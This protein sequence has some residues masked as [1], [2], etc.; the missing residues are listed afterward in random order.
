MARRVCVAFEKILRTTPRNEPMPDAP[1]LFLRTLNQPAQRGDRLPAVRFD[2]IRIAERPGTRAETGIVQRRPLG[3]LR[4][5]R[6]NGRYL[7]QPVIRAWIPTTAV[8]DRPEEIVCRERAQVR[9]PR[10]ALFDVEW[11][12]RVSRISAPISTPQTSSEP[13]HF[14]PLPG[15]PYRSPSAAWKRATN[16]RLDGMLQPPSHHP[17]LPP[18]SAPYSALCARPS[19]R[20][21]SF[22]AGRSLPPGFQSGL[23]PKAETSRRGDQVAEGYRSID[24]HIDAD[25]SEYAPGERSWRPVVGSAEVAIWP[26]CHDERV[27]I[28][29]LLFG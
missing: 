23:E 26:L 9:T 17:V 8:G 3:H 27:L 15:A 12:T 16:R 22:Q 28:R 5:A 25:P 14:G 24:R 4:G 13:E 21:D 18:A 20:G 2:G 1:G 10:L 11:P 29:R 7:R 6:A 19:E